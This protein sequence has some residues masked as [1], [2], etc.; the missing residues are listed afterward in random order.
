MLCDRLS[1]DPWPRRDRLELP[2]WLGKSLHQIKISRVTCDRF[3][4]VPNDIRGHRVIY[5]QPAKTC[6]KRRIQ[7]RVG[8]LASEIDK[9]H[10]RLPLWGVIKKKLTMVK[11]LHIV[12]V[13][14]RV[15]ESLGNSIRLC[16]MWSS[17]FKNRAFWHGIKCKCLHSYQAVCEWQNRNVC[18]AFC[19]RA[20]GLIVSNRVNLYYKIQSGT[21]ITR[22]NISCYYLQ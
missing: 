15:V 4:T 1:A 13:P 19:R 14:M 16:E 18:A 7:L 6:D 2:V 9:F 20:F 12:R 10:V 5:Y 21:F 11:I 3:T 22:S 8:S 17:A